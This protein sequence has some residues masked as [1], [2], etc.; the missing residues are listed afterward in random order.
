M[1][2]FKGKLSLWCSSSSSEQQ[3]AGVLWSFQKTRCLFL[4]SVLVNANKRSLCSTRGPPW[5]LGSPFST[6]IHH[7]SPTAGGGM[8][9]AVRWAVRWWRQAGRWR[10]W[11][12]GCLEVA[13]WLLRVMSTFTNEED[14]GRRQT[15]HFFVP[16]PP[17]F[18]RT[19]KGRR[20]STLKVK[21]RC[22]EFSER[23]LTRWRGSSRAAGMLTS[24]AFLAADLRL[25]FL[26][27]LSRISLHRCQPN[28]NTKKAGVGEG[29]RQTN[30]LMLRR[31]LYLVLLFAERCLFVSCDRVRKL[32]Q[33][34]EG[35][36]TTGA[37]PLNWRLWRSS[38]R[39][40]MQI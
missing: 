15:R 25:T 40:D 24:L 3:N 5:R 37:P 10:R 2:Y 14:A 4:T 28:N 32:Q 20:R 33:C 6:K 34:V 38:E 13:G 35:L 36:V 22:R 8:E 16:L 30:A 7:L 39:L 26:H 29:K 9:S 12:L 1:L 18:P 21:N 17:S 19:L 11:S 27:L 31:L 23:V